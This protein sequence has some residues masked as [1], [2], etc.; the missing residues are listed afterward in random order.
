MSSTNNFIALTSTGYLLPIEQD[1]Q[2]IDGQIYYTTADCTGTEYITYMIAN[3]SVFRNGSNLYYTA[4]NAAAVDGLSFQS[5]RNTSTGGCD[6]G[7]GSKGIPVT[8]NNSA[9]TGVSQSSF[10]QPITIE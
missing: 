8:A 5:Y 9:V 10:T 2:V 6:A 3:K 4:A 1:G 7:S